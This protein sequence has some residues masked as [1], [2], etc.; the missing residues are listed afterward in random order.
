MRRICAGLGA[1]LAAVLYD[2]TVPQYAVRWPVLLGRRPSPYGWCWA[3][4]CEA[5]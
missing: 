1:F 3:W 4:R 2:P 5:A